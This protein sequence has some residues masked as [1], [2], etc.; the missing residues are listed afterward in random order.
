MTRSLFA[1]RGPGEIVA[2]EGEVVRV[3]YENAETSFR[4]IRVMID[5]EKR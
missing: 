5:A 1:T 4:V 2:V 3:S